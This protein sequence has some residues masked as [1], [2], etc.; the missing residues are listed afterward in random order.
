MISSLSPRTMIFFAPSFS[1]SCSA[2]INALYSATLFVARP[3]KRP[4]V[5][6]G[7]PSAAFSTIPTP[8]GPGFPRLPP[9]NC[10]VITSSMRDVYA[11]NGRSGNGPQFPVAR[12]LAAPYTLAAN[13]KGP[14]MLLIRRT[15]VVLF[16]LC[17]VS[18]GADEVVTLATYNV[19]HFNDH[20]SAYE[21]GKKLSKE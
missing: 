8:A 19:E 7:V 2:V 10:T 11:R 3:I 13:P 5:T 18:R 6:I 14:Q 16:L 9:S 1:A 4:S 17:G 12:S 15:L 20:F 21:L